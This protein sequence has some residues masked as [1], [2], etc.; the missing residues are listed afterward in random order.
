MQ[1]LSHADGV[2][3]VVV[4][5]GYRRTVFDMVPPLSLVTGPNGEVWTLQ[6][7][8]CIE[9]TERARF[10]RDL[11]A[12]TRI[13][14]SLRDR[15]LPGVELSIDVAM[16]EDSR[17]SGDRWPSLVALRNASDRELASTIA[18]STVESEAD[19]VVTIRYPD[20]RR[21]T[22]SLRWVEGRWVVDY[23]KLAEDSPLRLD[24][25][26][27]RNW[28]YI[29]RRQDAMVAGW[30]P[31]WREVDGGRG[32]VIGHDASV[33][34][35]DPRD[36]SVWIVVQE[37]DPAESAI[38]HVDPVDEEVLGRH[39]LP[40]RSLRG[41][42]T[43]GPW[44][45]HWRATMRSNGSSIL[46]IGHNGVWTFDT[47]TGLRRTEAQFKDI[48][49]VSWGTGEVA[50][51]VSWARRTGSLTIP[52]PSGSRRTVYGCPDPIGLFTTPTVSTAV[53]ATG[54]IE[55]WVHREGTAEVLAEACDGEITGAS[56]RA[57]GAWLVICGEE[58]SHAWEVHGPLPG[59]GEWGGHRG[60]GGTLAAWS[61]DGR[62]VLTP[63][64]ADTGFS[65]LLWDVRSELPQ[66]GFGY[67]PIRH[68]QFSADGESLISVDMNG[69]VVMWD[70][71]ALRTDRGLAPSPSGF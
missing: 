29:S 60:T 67:R 58:A 26:T 42:W 4:G 71:P 49:A 63:A 33:A 19:G 59:S 53:C 20:G 46:L 65:A 44:R 1:A 34:L 68:A 7:T 14:G 50:D 48:S 25:S 30:V 13:R 12:E 2:A 11:I 64:P 62:E 47:T 6:P 8:T 5:P 32:Q 55:R 45:R 54:T 9:C 3:T 70:L 41:N 66:L 40:A 31:S 23:D 35:P 43:A 69:D 36:G 61:P 17:L 52:Q 10:V 24:R 38:F 27:A 28:R 22:W 21:D 39:E 57:D 51:V 15:L 37:L 56:A 16:E 18:T